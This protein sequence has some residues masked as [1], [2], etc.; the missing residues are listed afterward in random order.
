MNDNLAE[1]YARTVADGIRHL[2]TRDTFEDFDDIREDNGEPLS[3]G[4]W[5]DDALDIIYYFDTSKRYRGARIAVTLGGPNAWVDTYR[6]TV[7]VY[8]GSDRATAT[9]PSKF[10][11]VLDDYLEE[12]SA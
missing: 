3:L 6:Q 12:V 5:L 2:S 1:D 11:N 9:L 10:I 8:W 7:E 4:A